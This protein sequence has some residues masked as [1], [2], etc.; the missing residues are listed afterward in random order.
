MS[1]TKDNTVSLQNYHTAVV[2]ELAAWIWNPYTGGVQAFVQERRRSLIAN[3]LLLL[4]SEEEEEEKKAG[5]S[6]RVM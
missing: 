1:V 3:L 6:G 4:C 5:L 2:E